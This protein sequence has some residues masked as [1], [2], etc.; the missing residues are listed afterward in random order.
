MDVKMEAHVAMWVD[1]GMNWDTSPLGCQEQLYKHPFYPVMLHS[2]DVKEFKLSL[3]SQ[4]NSSL[5]FLLLRSLT[6]LKSHRTSLT[7]ASPP[8]PSYPL[9][10]CAPTM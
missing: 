10:A 9:R 2:G 5:V 3:N 1:N 7:S 6:D 8:P 4:F